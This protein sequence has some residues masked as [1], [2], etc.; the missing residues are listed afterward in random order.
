MALRD[1]STGPLPSDS[2]VTSLPWTVNTILAWGRSPVSLCWERETKANCSPTCDNSSALT[3]ARMSSSKISDLRSASSLKRA[4]AAL[5]SVSLSIVTPRSCRRCL[6]ALRP[7]S[8]P[9]TILLAV[10]PTSS[11]RMIS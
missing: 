5:T 8:L 2:L 11:A 6:K 1:A 9:S 3:S 4:N 7:L 10:Q